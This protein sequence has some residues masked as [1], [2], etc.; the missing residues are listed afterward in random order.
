MPNQYAN[1][2]GHITKVEIRGLHNR[3]DIVQEFQEGLNIIYG[4]NGKGKT[5][6]LHIISNLLNG[7]YQRFTSL[8]FESVRIEFSECEPLKFEIDIQTRND[9]H[10]H[11][12][13]KVNDG[14]AH[15]LDPDKAN[16]QGKEAD[17]CERWY[18]KNGLVNAPSEIRSAIGFQEE[19]KELKSY[20]TKN[21]YF[22]AFRGAI[23]AMSLRQPNTSLNTKQKTDEARKLFG[24]FVP[25]LEYAGLGDIERRLDREIRSAAGS[26]A[27]QDRQSRL[28]VYSSIADRVALEFNEAEVNEAIESAV[29]QL[30]P[31]VPNVQHSWDDLK[32]KLNEFGEQHPNM[33]QAL[34][35]DFKDNVERLVDAEVENF[36]KLNTFLDS[37]NSF[38]DHKK[39]FADRGG[40]R[41][42]RAVPA[43]AILRIGAQEFPARDLHTTLSSGERQLLTLLFSAS[44][45]S[46]EHIVLIDE[47]EISLHVDWQRR[48]L[49][50]L[51]GQLTNKQIIVCTHSAT[52]GANHD[53]RMFELN[54]VQR[55]VEN[56]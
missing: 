12:R 14:I 36:S 54:S 8:K 35:L 21:A 25:L 29:K 24:D 13:I 5:S 51:E 37:F 30:G 3:F 55:E 4:H 16:N 20:E 6:L 2:I 27:S 23:D 43:R 46:D 34:L 26:V 22:P 41:D 38:L 40:Q 39:L 15:F 11:W 44:F 53:D 50:S 48:L 32:Q 56:A 10:R 18:S 19:L 45:M 9:G 17:L 52:I 1:P 7:D 49:S 47:P 31:Y 28:A 33:K 42:G